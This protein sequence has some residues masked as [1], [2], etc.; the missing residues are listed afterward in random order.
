MQID[1]EYFREVP[2]T[3]D[4]SYEW[5]E[6]PRARV[7]RARRRTPAEIERRR[8]L[9]AMAFFEAVVAAAA[10]E[11]TGDSVTRVTQFLAG[12]EANEPEACRKCGE[13]NR[14]IHPTWGVCFRCSGQPAF[15]RSG[16]I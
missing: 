12:L 4:Q 3:L 13:T 8:G 9:R 1:L 11:V 15:G 5:L 10:P 2:L 16:R 14:K 6:E 7:V